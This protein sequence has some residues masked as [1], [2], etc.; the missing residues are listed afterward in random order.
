MKRLNENERRAL[1]VI[2]ETCDDLDGDLFTRMSDV[3][4]ALVGVFH[5]GKV[6]GGY[7]ADLIRKGYLD[8]EPDD[9][10]GDGVWVNA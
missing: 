4:L 1:D 8:V 9:F 5:D 7:I 6:A 2:V 10:Y 3:V